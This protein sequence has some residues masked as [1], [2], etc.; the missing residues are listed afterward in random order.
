MRALL[1]FIAI[2]ALAAIAAVSFGFLRIDQTRRAELP[3]VSISGG[4][5][6]KFDVHTVKVDIGTEKKAIDVPTV[7]VQRPKE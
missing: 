2:V 3:R 4:Q 6:P 1:S 5:A 7:S